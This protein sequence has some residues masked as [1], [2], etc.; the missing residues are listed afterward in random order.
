[1]DFDF[2]F[3]FDTSFDFGTDTEGAAS[4]DGWVEQSAKFP[5]GH[6]LLDDPR[7]KHIN[8]STNNISPFFKNAK[9]TALKF[10]PSADTNLFVWLDG[11]FI[12]GDLIEA[13]LVHQRMRAERLDI[14]TLSLDMSNFTSLHTLVTKG[15]IGKLNLFVSRGWASKYGNFLKWGTMLLDNATGAGYEGVSIKVMDVHAKYAAFDIAP[16]RDAP[17]FKFIMHGSANLRSSG[18]VE[19]LRIEGGDALVDFVF[20]TNSRTLAAFE[21][22]DPD[23]PLIRNALWKAMLPEDYPLPAKIPGRKE[24]K[25]PKFETNIKP[26]E[27]E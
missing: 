18:T 14:S 17:A 10:R 12:F 25:K 8:N 13:I 11:S 26:Y 21:L 3:D 19:Q 2:D 22:I 7:Y 9:A 4:D 16:R 15:Y 27:Y 5:V 23:K 20:Q 24:D 1:M 6:I